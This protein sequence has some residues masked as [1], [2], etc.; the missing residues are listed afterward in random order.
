[1]TTTWVLDANSRYE[2][3]SKNHLLQIMNSGSLFTDAGSA[4]TDYMTSS[5]IQTTDIDLSGETVIPIGTLATPFEGSYDGGNNKISNWSLSGSYEYSGL[6]GYCV[7]GIVKNLVLAGVWV[8]D[9]SASTITQAVGFLVGR[10]LG[11]Y[12]NV[13]SFVRSEIYNITAEFE[14]G[15]I[16]KSHSSA[17]YSGVLIGRAFRTD[18]QAITVGGVVTTCEGLSGMAGV[19][20]EVNNCTVFMMRNI[21]TFENGIV[22]LNSTGIF[23]TIINS[24]V[25]YIMNAM[26]GDLLGSKSSCG[27]SYYMLPNNDII[28]VIVNAMTGDMMD[29]ENF[30]SGICAVMEPQNGSVNMTRLMNYMNGDLLKTSYSQALFGSPRPRGSDPITISNSI[31]AMKGTVT[32]VGIVERSNLFNS[33]VSDYSFGMNVTISDDLESGTLSGYTYN[34]EFGDLP[35]VPFIGTDI[36]GTEHKWEFVFPNVSGKA[37]YSAYSDV[38]ISSGNKISKPIRIEF[39]FPQSNVVEYATFYND[40]SSEAYVDDSLAILDS[41]ASAIYD[42][43]GVNQKF[44]APIQIIMYPVMADIIWTSISGASW[45]RVTYIKDGGS[46]VELVDMTT[47]NQV[48]MTNVLPE[49]SYEVRL[50]TDL[51]VITP[52][53][54]VFGVS[55]ST[56]NNSSISDLLIRIDNDLTFLPD[57]A[58]R[59]IKRRVS[60]SLSTGDIVTT[61]RG[62][63]RIV[64]NSE[65]VQIPEIGDRIL[66]EF[67]DT[68]GGGQSFDVT[69]PDTSSSTVSYNETTD[70]VVVSSEEY[71]DG[72]YF[73]LGGFKVI[74]ENLIDD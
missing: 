63:A 61:S 59:L 16:Y 15:T 17:S 40:A 35:Y 18:I 6:F 46:E 24:N 25:T 50:Y 27:I 19:I 31:V 13:N 66:T 43:T 36:G 22:G 39:D 62:N 71:G 54:T 20:G 26:K 69:L 2:V 8:L 23:T 73:V 41:D 52:T 9:E 65:N 4:P 3:S 44:P 32:S 21:A 68:S 38:A 45:Y 42:Y 56:N 67:V 1:M 30:C 28:D 33:G 14:S 10:T 7:E 12:V 49:S 55:P 51:D 57:R 74:V 11:T 29:A 37:A 70:S 53:R 48:V 58:L 72:E 64:R 60:S 5:Y 34:S 47:E